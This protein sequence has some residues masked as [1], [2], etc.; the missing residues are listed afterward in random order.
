MLEIE[1][2]GTAPG[3]LYDRLTLT[4]NAGLGG[5]LSIIRPN[6][7][8]PATGDSF[9]V[10]THTS[11]TGGF[12]TITGAF[13]NFDRHFTTNVSANAVTL[14]VEGGAA[15]TD[16]SSMMTAINDAFDFFSGPNGLLA[17]W[18]T[19]FD[20]GN[21]S[22]DFAGFGI[23]AF[24]MPVVGQD[25]G[26]AFGLDSLLGNLSLGFI[27]PSNHRRSYRYISG[28]LDA[29]AHPDYD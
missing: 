14:L 1:I 12:T 4:G 27:D 6:A 11:V 10:I 25:I 9:D 13:I 17:Q 28:I 8:V 29:L 20:F 3:T 22:P 26:T 24:N 21:W 5:T 23:P 2:A 16:P 19:L 7:F 18:G 15:G